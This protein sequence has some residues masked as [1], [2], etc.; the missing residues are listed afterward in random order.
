MSKNNFIQESFAQIQAEVSKSIIGNAQALEA[1]FIAT[2]CK[3]HVLLE[4]MPGLAKTMLAK[5][6]AKTV[7][8]EFGRV[9]FTPDLLPSDL[10][11]TLVYQPKDGTFTTRKGPIFT[12]VLLADEINRAP[13]K[14][15]SALLQSMEERA[16]T[17]GDTTF[18]LDQYF[19]VI[20][21]ENPI[22]TEGTY[23]LPEAQLDRFLLKCIL[24]Y[25]SAEEEAN[26]T[27]AYGNSILQDP[28]IQKVLNH[29][30]LLEMSKEVDG[31]FLE[32]AVHEYIV[33]LVQSSRPSQ[34]KITD[35]KEFL[36]FG[37]SPRATLSLVKISKVLARL[38]GRD[39][40]IPDDVKKYFKP[41]MNHRIKLS[42]AAWSEGVTADTILDTILDSTESP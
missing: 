42:Y 13:A 24:D 3:G 37:A 23:P 26:I 34:S 4:G 6:F 10:T 25:P 11:G 32:D 20:A 2:L 36:A 18:A 15:Q 28:K 41:V 7:D 35:I 14:V 5:T 33:K 38:N 29:A 1:L 27:K 30:N 39:Y 40:V 12:G 19:T 31:I 21:T 8:L 17:L 22:E 16:V 9:Q